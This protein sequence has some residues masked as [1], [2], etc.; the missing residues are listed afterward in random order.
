MKLSLAL[1]RK[2]VSMIQPQGNRI[3]LE[4]EPW[5][6]DA[7]GIQLVDSHKEVQQTARVVGIGAGSRLKNGCVEFPDLKLGDRVITTQTAGT[8]IS[9]SDTKY[10]IVV[11]E[12]ITGVVE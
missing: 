6:L 7:D 5:D 12:D 8:M 4:L 11:Q 1:K 10:Q 9:D 3:L 2:G